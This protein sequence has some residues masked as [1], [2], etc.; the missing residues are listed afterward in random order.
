[1]QAIVGEADVGWQGGFSGGVIEIVAHVGEEGALGLEELDEGG[2]LGYVGVA[3][4]GFVAESIED[5]NVEVLEEREALGGDVGH[6]GEVGGGAEAVA[7]D[8]LAAVGDGDAL[9]LRAEEGDGGARGG[10]DAVDLYAGAGGVAVFG[11]EGVV[12]DAL[13]GEGSRVVGV[14]GEVAGDV[15]A[16]GAQIVEAHDV[17]SVAVGVENGVDAADVLADGLGVEVGAGVDEDGAVEFSLFVGEADGG[18]G[19]TVARLGRRQ[20]GAGRGGRGADRA[21]A[22]ESGDAHGGAATE[23]GEGCFH[24]FVC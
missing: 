9:E 3:A 8:G 20:V 15:E 17:I 21:W 12:E 24:Q 18:A 7:G 4:V 23:K 22:S 13:E 11:A 5:E 16:E 19:A 1:M 14:D 10:G 6:V 2:G